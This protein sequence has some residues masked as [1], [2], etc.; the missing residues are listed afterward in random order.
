MC[1]L[2][3]FKAESNLNMVTCGGQATVP[4]INAIHQWWGRNA[5]IIACIAS[6]SAGQFFAKYRWFTRQRPKL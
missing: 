4:I 5:E 1:N 6:K 3:K 2:E